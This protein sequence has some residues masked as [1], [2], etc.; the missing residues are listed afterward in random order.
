MSDKN[1]SFNDRLST[2]C[3]A[4]EFRKRVEEIQKKVQARAQQEE[5]EQPAALPQKEAVIAEV[6]PAD[7]TDTAN[8]TPAKA[9]KGKATDDGITHEFI[10]ECC[11][12]EDKGNG[13]LYATLMRERFVHVPEAKQWMEW[14]DHYWKEIFPFVVEASVERV[15]EQYVK[16]RA[17]EDAAAR[18][19]ERESEEGEDGGGNK[20]AVSQAKYR[21]KLLAKSILNLH[22]SAGV[23]SCIKFALANDKPLMVS[24]EDLDADHYKIACENGVVDIRTGKFRAGK[25]TDNITRVC[26]HNWEGINAPCEKWEAMLFQILGERKDVFD[27][28]W[29]ILGM[30]ICGEISEKIFLI[31]LG[32][33]GDS[34]KTTIFEIIYEVFKGYAAPMQV[35]M[36]LDQGIPQNP[37]SP[38]PAI[39]SLRGNRLM[40]ASEPGENRRFSIERVK[41]MSGNDSLVGRYPWD[42]KN[43]TFQPTHTLFLLTNHKMRAAAHDQPFWSRVRLIDCPFSFVDDPQKPNQRKVNRNLKKEIIAT[44]ASGIIA[45]VVR[46]YQKYVCEGLTPPEV[47][48]EATNRYRTEE[49]LIAQFIDACIE[50]DEGNRIAASRL[51]NVFKAWFVDCLGKNAPSV[52][53]FGKL[54]QRQIRKEKAGGKVWYYDIEINEEA[55]AKYEK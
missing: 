41:L 25:P 52:T 46:G 34:G 1:D 36:L 32:E 40:W 11:R 37:N 10:L 13:I 26:P 5:E 27:Y 55:R 38:T 22:R 45:F 53:T 51:Y 31:L 54:A 3:S 9:K 24:A 12:A 19:A 20:K 49:D 21:C 35:E 29:K 48:V 33:E 16:A 23:S 50:P 47:I 17:I 7:T 44:E 18:D 28:F 8:T 6:M 30:A 4:D 15:A 39:M 2:D 14:G 42:T 43:T